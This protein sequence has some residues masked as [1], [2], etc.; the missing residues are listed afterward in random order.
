MPDILL[1]E[2]QAERDAL[3]ARVA[4]LEAANRAMTETAMDAS[5]AYVEMHKELVA[6]RNR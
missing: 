5:R 3:R 4:E 1:K 6:L 2:V